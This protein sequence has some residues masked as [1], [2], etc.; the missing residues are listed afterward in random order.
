MTLERESRSIEYKR[1]MTELRKIAQTVV[2][3]ANGSGGRILI[4]VDDAT[5]AV[6]GLDPAAIDELL[7]KLPVSLADQIQPP[8]FPQIFEQTIN[9]REV[10]IVQVFPGGQKPYYI[11]A[12][13]MEKGVYIRVGAHTRRAEG[14]LLEELRLL[15]SRLGYDEAILPDCSIQELRTEL[16][17]PALR[18]EKG[19]LSLDI[20]RPDTFSGESRPTRGGI[21]MLSDNP[22]KYVP[23]ARCIVSRMRG[24]SGRNTIETIDIQ[25]HLPHQSDAAVDVLSHWLG[26]NPAIQKSRY[27]EQD[28]I[29]PLPAVREAINNALFHRQYS[30]PGAIKIAYYADRLEVFSPGHFAGPFIQDSLGDGTSYI[31]NKVI[32]L[33]ARRMQLIEKRGTGIRLI[34]DA[35]ANKG[36]AKPRFIEGPNWF[37]VVLPFGPQNAVGAGEQSE[38]AILALFE[39][40]SQLTSSDVCRALGVSK[41]TAVGYLEKLRQKGRILRAG[42]GPKTHYIVSAAV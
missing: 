19:L 26:R 21:L 7:E 14:E 28:F 16:L 29:L 38:P 9:S 32:C 6:R 3:F 42:K 20:A 1:E 15:R 13:G 30:I 35:M 27:S 25:G 34:Q 23:E 22:E 5:R 36:L 18:T 11:A 12:E 31:R 8:L 41:A 39:R 17:P 10:L 37:K 2:A 24:D 33:V 4:G 40:E